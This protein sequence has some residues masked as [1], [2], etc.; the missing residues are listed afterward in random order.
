MDDRSLLPGWDSVPE[1]GV[2]AA[3]PPRSV[4]RHAEGAGP[5]PAPP[6]TFGLRILAV[7][8]V[9]RAIREAVRADPRLT[10]VWVEGEVGRVTV[11]SAGHAYFT[12]KDARSTLN[13]VWFSDE[14]ARSAFQP[15]AGL[16]IV[17]HGRVDLFEQQG[18]VQLYVESIQPAGFGD[19]AIRFEALKAR[20]SAEGLFDA[21][22]KRTLPQRPTTIAVITSPT[23]VVWRDVATV[24]T[25]RWPLTAVLLV[26]CKV[27]GDDAPESIVRAFGRLERWIVVATRD[28][29]PEDVPQVTILARG[30]GSLEDLWS[31]N[32]ERVV[33]AVVGHSLPVVCGV[34]HEVDVTLADFAADVRAATP[35]AAAELVVP[36]RA[37]WMAA[38]RRAGERTAAAVGRT[39]DA[40][41]R[42]LAAERRALDR[43]DPRAQLVA[44]RE[45]VGLLLDRA[46]RVAD[47]AIIRRRSVLDAAAS[48]APRPI[49]ARLLAARSTLDATASALAVLDPQATLERGYA[50]VRR[51]IDGRI[52]R[53][54]AEAP[55]GTDLSV[56]LAAGD[57]PA[58]A[59]EGGA[60]A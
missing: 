45:R 39:L 47:G 9:A 34:G 15:Q 60:R 37:D 57:L 4:A 20:L 42:E 50:I 40:A 14:R 11:S 25:R 44:D 41:G 53:D 49:L 48:A 23:G 21:G 35:S 51:A 43:L 31:F 2:P 8:E 58:T 7:S 46:V 18:A 36:D 24:L 26:A 59:G 27:Q 1:A 38:F 56:R 3:V 19:L 17:V 12:L 28:G 16:R 22:R 55:A 13:C 30:G 29:R 33:R 10:D 5:V 52:L 32:D 54:P 6:G